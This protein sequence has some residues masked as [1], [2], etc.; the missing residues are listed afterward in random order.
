MD[1]TAS[2]DGSLRGATPAWPARVRGQKSRGAFGGQV[3]KSGDVDKLAVEPED[4]AEPSVA[5]AQRIGRDGIEHRLGVGLRA[6]DDAQ[7]FARRRLLL[8]CFRQALLEL[9]AR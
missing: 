3:L 9:L 5:Q 2:Q 1:D 8:Q 4:G 6:A 7:Y